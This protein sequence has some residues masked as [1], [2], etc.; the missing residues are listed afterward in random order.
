[1]GVSSEGEEGGKGGRKEKGEW[2]GGERMGGG[3]RNERGRRGEE[4]KSIDQIDQQ[5]AGCGCGKHLG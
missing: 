3:G 2:G 1:M 4:D 5:V